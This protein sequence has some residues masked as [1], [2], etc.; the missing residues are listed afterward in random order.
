[1]AAIKDAY[2]TTT[3]HVAI[4][5]EDGNVWALKQAF[6]DDSMSHNQKL[7]RAIDLFKQDNFTAFEKYNDKIHGLLHV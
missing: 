6:L 2:E 1:M 4:R 7:E 5:D 3:S